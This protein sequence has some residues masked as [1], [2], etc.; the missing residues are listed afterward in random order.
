MFSRVG[1]LYFV[2]FLV[3]FY[4]CDALSGVWRD[5]CEDDKCYGGTMSLCLVK[6]NE[7]FGRYSDI[8]FIRGTINDDGR[9]EGM[10]FEAGY[11]Q[12]NKGGF[13]WRLTNNNGNEFTGSWWFSDRKCDRFGW[14]SQKIDSATPS[15][16]DCGVLLLNVDDLGKF[17]F[18]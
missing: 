13:E 2:C 6:D 17:T 18:M 15:F 8:G 10:W 7:I 12:H 16:Y 1:L 3:L 14:A 5:R 11:S 4:S 9:I